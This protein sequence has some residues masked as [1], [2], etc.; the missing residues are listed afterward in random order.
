[1]EACWAHNPEVRGSKPRSANVFC[2]SECFSACHYFQNL[3]EK[4]LNL[5]QVFQGSAI[6]DHVYSMNN[7]CKRSRALSAPLNKKK[8][9]S[10]AGNRT[11]V[12]RVTGGDTYHYTTE[13]TFVFEK[14]SAKQNRGT[15]K[16]LNTRFIAA[17]I[18]DSHCGQCLVATTKAQSCHLTIYIIDK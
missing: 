4:K 14:D 3:Y 18:C 9:S 8:I 11:P 7:L 5:L 6:C 15:V 2:L 12:S 17:G 10:P 16:L 1:M 13:D